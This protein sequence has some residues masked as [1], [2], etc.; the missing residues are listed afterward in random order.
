M[1]WPIRA[2]TSLHPI[3][4]PEKFPHGIMHR[5]SDT[6]IV[7]EIHYFTFDSGNGYFKQ[8]ITNFS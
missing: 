8:I 2:A 5:I 1:P 7:E 4:L 3:L 6:K